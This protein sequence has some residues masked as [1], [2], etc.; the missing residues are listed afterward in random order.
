M[1]RRPLRIVQVAPSDVGGGAEK[2][3]VGLLR[4]YRNRG[5]EAVLVVG[6]KW[7]AEDAVVQI[8]SSSAWT[9]SLERCGRALERHLGP[10]GRPVR[11]AVGW[12]AMPSRM[13][14]FFFGTGEGDFPEGSRI[15]EAAGF[16]PDV[17]H[18]HNLHGSDDAYGEYLNPRVLPH[19]SRYFP[20]FLTLHDS[21]L[22]TG[23]CMNPASCANWET[24]CAK[25]QDAA[26]PAGRR[27][28]QA[29][30]NWSVKRDLLAAS[31]LFVASPSRWMMERALRSILAPAIAGARVIPNGVDLSV[32]CPGGRDNERSRL[33]LPLEALVVLCVACA[34]RRNLAKDLALAVDSC[35]IAAETLRS[36]VLLLVVGD[37]GRTIRRGLLTVRFCGSVSDSRIIARFY[38]AADVYLHP[39]RVDTFPTTVI[40]AM[41]CGRPVAATAV[42][43]IPEQIVDGVTGV[44]AP[45][46]D[47][48]AMADALVRLLCDSAFRGALGKAAARAAAE[49]FDVRRQASAYLQWYQEVLTSRE[50][51]RGVTGGDGAPHRH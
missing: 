1:N 36:P 45:A 35:R 7:T 26:A 32:F 23:L 31:R 47:A 18:F 4:E 24:G 8:S 27:T 48:G 29:P 3:A 11:K 2:V 28:A 15:P 19:L 17:L 25:C 13:R 34:M 51:A 12:V 49:R 20:V 6:R 21:W 44:L 16:P 40:E 43:G 39:A 37:S 46:G 10:W 30:R 9:S 5:H 41:A 38:R 50:T 33:G 22:F 14:I 42:G